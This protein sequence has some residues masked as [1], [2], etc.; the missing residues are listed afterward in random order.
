MT[1]PALTCP[2][3]TE[4][5][6]SIYLK[7]HT[8]EERDAAISEAAITCLL[9]LKESGRDLHG[10]SAIANAHDLKDLRNA[11]HI[12]KWNLLGVS[13]GTYIAQEA[14]R[15]DATGIRSM[16]LD[17]LV[18]ME[19]DLFMSE[20]QKNYSD[21]MKQVINACEK[22]TACQQ[23]FPK[24]SETLQSL[25]QSLKNAPLSLSLESKS[26]MVDMVVNWHDFLNLTHWMLYNAKTLPLIPL[27]IEAT[28]SGDLVLLTHLM[29]KVFP[30]PKNATES[31]AGTFFAV[32]CQ[33]QFTMRNPIPKL[34]A[35]S[36][37]GNFAITSFMADICQS[38]LL[39]YGTRPTPQ[40]LKSDIPTLLF[41]GTFDPMTPSRYASDVAKNL[42]NSTLIHIQ[43][44]GHSTL[45]GYKECQTDIAAAFL[46]APHEDPTLHCLLNIPKVDFLTSREMV[47]SKLGISPE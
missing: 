25:I 29:N 13:Y 46:D 33:D 30:A 18:S 4:I 17:S 42:K 14:A 10:Y 39:E 27:L 38:P 22:S 11:L 2:S 16:V 1:K 23:H 36:D 8:L 21:G 6:N 7:D 19:S 5:R 43:N 20:A 35:P 26:G 45:S 37:Y 24:L 44:Y 9:Q 32:V 34:S 28:Y 15:I 47:Y 3:L 31:A 12:E 40:P 41:S